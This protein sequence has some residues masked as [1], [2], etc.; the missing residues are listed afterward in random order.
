MNTT[1]LTPL[2]ASASA[3]PQISVLLAQ[4]GFHTWQTLTITFILPP[5]NLVGAVFCSFSLWI[6]LRSKT[7]SDPIYFYYKLLCLVNIIH[8]LHNILIFVPFLPLYFSWIN[9]YV[10]S[11]CKMYHTFLAVLSA[12]PSKIGIL[13]V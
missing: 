10:I 5:I 9:S 3:L 1:A 4:L 6:F 11:V 13:F 7:F 2:N 12:S 8:S